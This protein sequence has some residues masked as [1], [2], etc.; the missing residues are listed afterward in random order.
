M[1]KKI[2]AL[3]VGKL[4]VLDLF[5]LAF[6]F[7]IFL[8]TRIAFLYVVLKAIFI[9]LLL[10]LAVG[11][12]HL[13][14]HQKLFLL[15]LMFLIV[16]RI[17][18]Y[19]HPTSLLFMSDNA[20]E[21]LQP[22]E[23]QDA[24]A[25]PFFLLNS[26]GHNGTLKYL[27]VAF[28]WDFLGT[29]YLTF[30]LFQLLIYAGFL[31]LVYDLLRRIFEEK[32]VLLMIFTQF[33]FIEV[34]FDY[35]LFLRAAPYLEMLFFFVL[36]LRLFDFA[37]R[38]LRRIFAAAY[39]FMIS[40]YLHSLAIFLVLPFL[41]TATLYAVKARAFLRPAAPVLAGGLAGLSHW[42]FY[43]LFYPPPPPTTWYK[44]YFFR[45]ADFS[46]K[47]I[48]VY[49][50]HLVRDF[51]I[52]FDNILSFEFSYHHRHWNSFEYYFH[53]PGVKT[54]LFILNRTLVF[55][56]LALFIGALVL[57]TVKLVRRRFFGAAAGDWIYPFALILFLV[58]LGKLFILSPAP[59][60]EPR[61]NIDLAFLLVLCL[62]IVAAAVFKVRKI[63]SWKSLAVVGISFLFTLPHYLT[64]LRVAAFKH[65]SYRALM[66]VLEANGI[67]YLNTDFSLAYVIHF[68]SNR[69]IKVTD[70]VGPTTLD[71]FYS[72][73]RKEVDALPAERQ[74]YI[75]LADE[76]PRDENHKAYTHKRMKG[77]LDTLK[78]RGAPYRIHR[79]KYYIL[80]I[81]QAS[82]ID[83]TPGTIHHAP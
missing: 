17:P 66:P 42:I 14:R 47:D 13:A 80:I 1:L 79:L 67:K 44:I 36:G 24:K 52:A 30:L 5:L 63:V 38:D 54:F 18:F 26:S 57:V 56:A 49:L 76:Y 72:W 45:P 74:A 60:Y 37:F 32:V 62:V 4:L 64:F 71:F 68:L 35:S 43:K 23:I 70:S 11:I 65:H 31:Y 58:F 69:K 12:V 2:L 83:K 25:A 50:A 61:H 53:S 73:M 55:L 19:S 51:W 27:C 46:L 10:L 15:G 33:A 3:P 20:L 29:D 59:H 28:I 75:F 82:R 9:G 8:V 22:L 81:P 48:P 41:L 39:F 77:V 6:G 34:L 78:T 21:A 7:Q 16:I 40:F